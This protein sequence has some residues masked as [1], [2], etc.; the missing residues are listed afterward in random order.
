MEGDHLYPVAASK[1]LQHDLVGAGETPLQQIR[2]LEEKYD[3]EKHSNNVEI[4]STDGVVHP[5]I[6]GDPLPEDPDAPFESVRDQITFRAIFVGCAIGAV[7]QASNLY[8]GLKT[9]VI[10]SRLS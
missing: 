4:T 8:L 5:Y 1:P 3:D 7:V 2:T 6:P 9:Y 10:P